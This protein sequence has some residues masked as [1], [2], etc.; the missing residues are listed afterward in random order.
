VRSWT[1][2]PPLPQTPTRSPSAPMV[3]MTLR[4]LP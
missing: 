4:M 2:Q 3:T 1:T